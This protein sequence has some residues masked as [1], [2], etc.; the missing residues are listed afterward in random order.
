LPGFPFSALWTPDERLVVAVATGDRTDPYSA[1]QV[2]LL[3]FPVAGGDAETI[4]LPELGSSTFLPYVGL[5]GMADGDLVLTVRGESGSALLRLA[6]DGTVTRAELPPGAAH[7]TLLPTG[8]VVWTAYV[9]GGGG[10]LEQGVRL[11]AAPFDDR[12]FGLTSDGR[13]V[14]E[15][16]YGFEDGYGHYAV[17]RTGVLAFEPLRG[18]EFGLFRIERLTERG[19]SEAF[20]SGW[21]RFHYPRVSPDGRWLAVTIH[22]EGDPHELFLYEV[23]RDAPTPLTT[24]GD[25]ILSVWHPS[26]PAMAYAKATESYRNYDL[27]LKR[28]DEEGDGELLLERGGAQLP[29]TWS[30]DGSALVFGE[31][32]GETGADLWLLPR[33]EE[34]RPLVQASGDQTAASVSPDGRWMLYSSDEAEGVQIYVRPFPGPG[35]ALRVSAGGGVEP[36]WSPDS[37]SVYY[38]DPAR[39]SLRRVS[40]SVS[41]DGLPSLGD[42]EELADDAWGSY[43]LGGPSYSV[44]PDGSLYALEA[45]G[46]GNEPTQLR[47]VVNWFE[48][49]ERLVPTE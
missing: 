12:R 4:E 11:F 18:D 10:A 22:G 40:F 14:M 37:S 41:A 28:I 38:R 26:E 20:L 45:K 34:P 2:E 24:S 6:S 36:L 21:R 19:E 43:A 5:Q 25:N 30:A 8:H 29:W 32:G 13:V 7:A 27:F 17:S 3:S 42:D 46:G 15:A 48:E 1:D 16:M 44:G 9:G 47:L 49:L 33:G 39:R 23:G 35:R 31:S